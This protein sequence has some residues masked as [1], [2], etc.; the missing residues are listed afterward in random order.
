[1]RRY[2]PFRFVWISD[3]QIPASD[4]SLFHSAFIAQ[5]FQICLYAVAEGLLSTLSLADRILGST[6]MGFLS[7]LS[8]YRAKTPLSIRTEGVK[9]RVTTSVQPHLTLRSHVQLT[10]L[11]FRATPSPYPRSRFREATPGGISRVFRA[12]TT[13][14]LSGGKWRLFSPIAVFRY[15]SNHSGFVKYLSAMYFFDSGNGE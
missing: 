15:P 8:P 13:G 10:P 12:R 6:S 14:K 2:Q 5:R 1:M 11:A 9:I 3:D 7:Y 4:A